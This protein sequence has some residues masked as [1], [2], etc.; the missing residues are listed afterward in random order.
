G[1]EI[2]I[3]DWTVRFSYVDSSLTVELN[4]NGNYRILAQGLRK[5]DFVEVNSYSGYIGLLESDYLSIKFRG[6][7]QQIMELR[8]GGKVYTAV[9]ARRIINVREGDDLNIYYVY[10]IRGRGEVE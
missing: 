5:G 3:F 8:R 6:Y 4:D 1:Y 2:D 10:L 9:S 7:K